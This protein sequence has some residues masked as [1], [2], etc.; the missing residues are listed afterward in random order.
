MITRSEIPDECLSYSELKDRIREEC[1]KNL[2]KK[3]RVLL[4]AKKLE[5]DLTLKDTICDQICTYLAHVTSE[6]H[7]RGCLPDEYKQANKK[8]V[9]EQS[10]SRLRNSAA[11]D[12]K[13]V[14][15]QKAMTVDPEGYEETFDAKR[16]YVEPAS[17][18]AKKI[19]EE[20]R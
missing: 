16:K 18:I 1:G 20:G 8:R 17:E 9:T 13:S 12:E 2:S 4:M 10:T 5:D 11:N 19:A 6:R 15:E 3:E 14:S 7:I